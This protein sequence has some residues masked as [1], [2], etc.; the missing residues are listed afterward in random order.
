MKGVYLYSVEIIGKTSSPASNYLNFLFFN[1]LRITR[2]AKII[3]N[4][5]SKSKDIC[6]TQYSSDCFSIS[7]FCSC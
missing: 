3:K 2:N 4:E 5:R 1:F 6:Y 7:C